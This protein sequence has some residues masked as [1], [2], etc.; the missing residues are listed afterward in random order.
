MKKRRFSREDWIEHGLSEL[1]AKGCEAV[2]LE[3]ICASAGLTRGS[4]YHHFEDHGAFLVALASHW[5]DRQTTEVAATVDPDASPEHQ[6]RALTDA[7]MQID[8]RLELGIRELGRRLPEVEA[9][10]RQAD[11]M[12]LDVMAGLYRA[13][14]DLEPETASALA[15]LEYATF[16][17]IILIDPEM[18]QE[19]QLAL[20]ELFENT[21]ASALRKD[22]KP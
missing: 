13:R 16:N 7:A 12:R 11:A 6:G 22:T 4:F 1:S 15:Y 9:I 10:V 3:A 8:Y 19:R 20:A 5:L 21:V 14:F 18:A 17:G 2:K